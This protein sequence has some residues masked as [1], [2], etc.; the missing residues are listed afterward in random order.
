[1]GTLRAANLARVS[2]DDSGRA[3]SVDEQ[4]ADN[5]AEAADIGA[6]ITGTYRDT[7]S[8]SRFAKGR[9][10][11]WPRLLAD[12]K[13]AKYD[14]V[15]LWESSRGSR[16]LE[17]WA[18]FLRLCRD[19]G[20]LIHVTTHHRS[21]D[22][23]IARDWR[24]LAE[25]GVDSQYE[26]EK[27]SGRVRRGLAANRDAGMPHSQAP[28]GYRRVYDERG[29]L[30]RNEAQRAYEPE[31][32]IVRHLITSVA[33][34]VPLSHLERETGVKR[35]TVRKICL[36]P[37]YTGKRRTPAGLVEARWKPLVDDATW[38]QAQA[39][40]AA[41]PRAGVASRPGGA[42]YLL[43]GIMTCFQCS[44]AVEADPDTR[45]RRACYACR[46]GHVTIAQAGADD[47][48]RHLTLARC[49]QDDLYQ[50]LTATAGS[51]AEAARAEADRL[52]AE[53]DEWLEAGISARAYRIKEDYYLPRIVAARDRAELLTVP[54]P[55]RDLVSAAGDVAGA[56]ERMTVAQRRGA[57]RF[58]F[59]GLTLH[60]S[61]RPGPGVPAR[62]RITW[63][64]RSFGG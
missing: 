4:H 18:R 9:R 7:M 5:E 14:L 52:Q 17:D 37:A 62:D 30:D 49:A 16:E 12:I 13:A 53:L 51:D 54:A 8:A 32:A 48:I 2:K 39:A 19:S 28:Y 40:L 56:W 10:E 22:M 1:M 25:D 23:S 15:L 55:V 33:A 36:N 45:G 44:A 6:V 60:K 50:L 3:R 31:A 34:G 47:V 35:S 43:S 57:V 58:L 29:K 26:S 11:D 38:R 64:W 24:V 61:P 21:Y 59:T 63:E 46:T 42:R 27:I 41:K 20:T